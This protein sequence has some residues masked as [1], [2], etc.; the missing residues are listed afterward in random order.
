[1]RKND[2]RRPDHKTLEELRARS[3]L[4]APSMS[5]LI[6]GEIV[7]LMVAPAY[8]R[9]GICE[10]T[11]VMENDE[12]SINF[13]RNGICTF[14]VAGNAAVRAICSIGHKCKVVG[15]MWNCKAFNCYMM[16]NITAVYRD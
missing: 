13:G 1:M 14:D 8:A 4:G 11:L 9:Q 12:I 5:W 2:A 16:S 15:D 6:A 3:A 7:A 10:G